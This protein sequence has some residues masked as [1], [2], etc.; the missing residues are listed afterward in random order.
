[1]R[2]FICIVNNENNVVAINVSSILY[3]T[4]HQGDDYRSI[5]MGKDVVINTHT[6]LDNLLQTINQL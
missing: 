5:Y 6:T 3:I 4:D 2:K 1:M